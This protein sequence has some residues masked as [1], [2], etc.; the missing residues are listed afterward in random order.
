MYMYMTK[1]YF[2]IISNLQTNCY[3]EQICQNVE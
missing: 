1:E 3:T 2:S